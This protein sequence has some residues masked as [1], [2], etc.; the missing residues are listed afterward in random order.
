MLGITNKARKLRVGYH[1]LSKIFFRKCNFKQQWPSLAFTSVPNMVIKI[2]IIPIVFDHS[3][4]LADYHWHFLAYRMILS[5]YATDYCLN[6]ENKRSRT[7]THT[8]THA[9]THAGDNLQYN[10]ST[11]W[12]I[13]KCAHDFLKY[14]L[15]PVY[16]III[17]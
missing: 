9:H 16:P 2:I 8:R 4:L 13:F 6:F 12:N 3:Q 14:M 10:I 11:E 7:H 15:C 1:R 5:V 17:L